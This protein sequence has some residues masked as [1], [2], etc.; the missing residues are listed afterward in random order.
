MQVEVSLTYGDQREQVN[1]PAFA[2]G[3][4]KGAGGGSDGG[5]GSFG[6]GDGDGDESSYG[7]VG[8]YRVSGYGS[9]FFTV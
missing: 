8:E 4:G 9:E 1:I 2:Y 3:A 7:F 6:G 5:Y